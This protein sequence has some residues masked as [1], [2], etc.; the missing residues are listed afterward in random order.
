M[1]KQTI[2]TSTSAVVSLTVEVRVG[3]WGPECKLSQVYDQ[4][5]EEAVNAIRNAVQK[6]GGSEYRIRV[7]SIDKIK[8]LTTEAERA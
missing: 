2:R 8:A 7:V 4:G 6:A 1:S 5:A 3:S